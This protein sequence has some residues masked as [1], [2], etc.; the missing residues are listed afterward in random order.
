[1]NKP[2]RRSRGGVTIQ[3]VARL[4]GVSPMT[5]SR[6]VN[7]D[8]NVRDTTR[9]AVLDA[10]RAL[11]YSPNVAARNL[12]GASAT[13]IGLLYSN[14]G[15]SYL[16]LFLV[17]AL[18]GCRRLGCQ[19]VIDSCGDT[20]QE[21]RDAARRLI[22]DPVEGV[23]LPA[24]LS[25]IPHI[26]GEFEAAGVAVVSVAVGLTPPRGLNV[27]IDD[28]K[29]AYEMTRRLI[30]LGHRELGFIR[31]HPNQSASEQR[32]CGFAAALREAGMDPAQAPVEQGYFSYRSGL[33]AAERLICRPSRPTAIFASNDDMAVATVAVAHRHG[34]QVPTDLS[35]V[36]FD[37]TSI[38]TT[39]WPELSTVRQ[40]ITAMAEAALELLFNELRARGVGETTMPIEHVLA[41]EVIERESAAAPRARARLKA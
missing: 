18:E 32:W 11:N 27:R 5:V 2:S 3:D 17:G 4:A 29:A 14:P 34:L 22:D 21:Q 25:E 1:M 30:A 12:A 23:I 13:H 36:G 31:G 6:V 40:P 20:E 28:F 24:P 26:A 15:A 19:L 7:G 39:V 9:G 16:S 8:K 41:H 33:E 10:V 37:D 35:V 38:A